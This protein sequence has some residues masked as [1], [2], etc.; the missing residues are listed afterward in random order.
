[1]K[2]KLICTRAYSVFVPA[3]KLKAYT[4][5]TGAG[6]VTLMDAPAFRSTAQAG[7]II[8]ERTRVG[9]ARMAATG[10]WALIS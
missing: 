9:A 7:E 4:L 5:G 3:G 8:I 2:Y 10:L 1:M 6:A